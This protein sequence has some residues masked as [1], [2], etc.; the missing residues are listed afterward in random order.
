[1]IDVQRA[2]DLYGVCGSARAAAARM[3]IVIG[4]ERLVLL[5]FIGPAFLGSLW[6]GVCVRGS[7]DGAPVG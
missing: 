3:G 7:Y 2:R 4:H 1:M 6:A 5:E